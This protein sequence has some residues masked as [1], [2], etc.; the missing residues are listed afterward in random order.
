[1]VFIQREI[2]KIFA[3]RKTKI[4]RYFFICS[5]LILLLMQQLQAQVD[6]MLAKTKAALIDKP[7]GIYVSHQEMKRAEISSSVALDIL[8][9]TEHTVLSGNL[10][11]QGYSKDGASYQV[12]IGPDGAYIWQAIMLH[13][14]QKDTVLLKG[15]LKNG[16]MTGVIVYQLQDGTSRTGNFTTIPPE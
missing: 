14:N 9:F 11:E 2:S 12:K 3:Y 10:S 13:E 16:V 6:P 8:A 5:F 7:W 4:L 15:E 1:M